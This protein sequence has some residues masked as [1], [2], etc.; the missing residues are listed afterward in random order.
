[1]HDI[2]R[3][4]SGSKRLTV[5][6]LWAMTLSLGVLGMVLSSTPPELI[7]GTMFGSSALLASV[8]VLRWREVRR[9]DS[10]ES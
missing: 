4:K 1:L 3:I 8:S 9:E 10:L 7:T 2:I 6:I 5:V